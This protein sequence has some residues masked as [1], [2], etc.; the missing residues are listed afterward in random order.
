MKLQVNEQAELSG[1]DLLSPGRRI[2]SESPLRHEHYSYL[3]QH[4]ITHLSLFIDMGR[5]HI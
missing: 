2:S 3:D 1:T 4:L 5:W